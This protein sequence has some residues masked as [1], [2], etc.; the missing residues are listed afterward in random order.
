MTISP[1]S[2]PKVFAL[3]LLLY[4]LLQWWIAFRLDSGSTGSRVDILF[5]HTDV[6]TQAS[7]SKIMCLYDDG[8]DEDRVCH[9]QNV[10]WDRAD[11]TFVLFQDPKHPT[12]NPLATPMDTE[13]KIVVRKYQYDYYMHLPIK[14]VVGV[15][16]QEDVTFSPY[17][18][19]LFFESFWPE[20]YAHALIDDI[21]PMYAI[22]H[23]FGM[24]ISG[25]L[26]LT[27][28]FLDHMNE[29]LQRRGAKI[30]TELS[31]VVLNASIHRTQ[32][33]PLFRQQG[34]TRRRYT[35]MQHLLAG[36]GNFENYN[37]WAIRA[38]SW[39]PFYSHVLLQTGAIGTASMHRQHL[40]VFIEKKGRRRILNLN[41]VA[42]MARDS[43]QVETV[44][45]DPAEM[46]FDEQ[47]QLAQRATV[48]FSP[49]GGISFFNAFLR[50]G[51]AAIILDFW[52]TSANASAS[53]DG[54]FWR[55]VTT[56]E[57]IRYP[58]QPQ[59][60]IIEPPG[61]DT[62]RG[63]WDYRNYGAVNVDL[64]RARR[65]LYRALWSTSQ[66]MGFD[67]NAFRSPQAVTESE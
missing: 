34:E 65:L 22:G 61:N 41:E 23:L 42:E 43:F 32:N 15:I 1:K 24:D 52:D 48:T 9:L 50:R 45:V 55:H 62:G 25:G 38:G 30:L 19:H 67:G 59:E 51:G 12:I 39:E 46:M 37:H 47:V 53:M 7:F 26:I 57:T 16:P 58:V 5:W 4:V 21:L 64:D 44:V 40:I 36:M 17:H 66:M 63:Y 13:R 27:Q 28:R 49:C 56:H 54:G 2:A 6:S 10:C 8:Q 14:Q 29:D 60:I 31:N 33:H 20:N 3:T 35:C 11:S 18:V